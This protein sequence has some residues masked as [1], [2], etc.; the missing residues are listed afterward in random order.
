QPLPEA[1]RADMSGGYRNGRDG[2]PLPFEIVGPAPAGSASVTGADM[3]RFMMAH[4][5]NGAGLLRPET[6]RMMH[7][8]VDRHFPGVN[9]MLLGF[10]QD[11]LNGQRII[12]H[13]GD[14]GY[15]HSQLALLLDQHVGVFIA[16]NSAGAPTPAAASMRWLFMR[17]FMDRYYP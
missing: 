8:T 10:Y 1:M 14:T 2:K 4:L 5:N 6:A 12:S 16:F 9:S 7:E 13:A 17:K 3:A 15:F 11:D